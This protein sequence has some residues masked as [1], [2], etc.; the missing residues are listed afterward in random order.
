MVEAGASGSEVMSITWPTA[1]L[2]KVTRYAAQADQK[3]RAT[4]AMG[5][6]SARRI[7]N[8]SETPGDKPVRG[9]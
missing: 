9:E 3:E 4:A 7:R 2:T 6:M 5:L 1:T 8:S